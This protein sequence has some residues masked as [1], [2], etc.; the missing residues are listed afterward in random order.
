MWLKRIFG[1]RDETTIPTS[2]DIPRAA[3]KVLIT[4]AKAILSQRLA[5]DEMLA[6]HNCTAL[7]DSLIHNIN[8][9]KS[10][11]SALA[12]ADVPEPTATASKAIKDGF[13]E[14]AMAALAR[15]SIPEWN[16]IA[17][18]QSS[19]SELER[20][21][22][23][24]S[25]GP[26]EAMH[27][28]FFFEEQMA[29][30]AALIH[31][32]FGTIEAVR[33][34][35]KPVAK[36]RREFNDAISALEACEHAIA[37]K[38]SSVKQNELEIRNAK[39]ELAGIQFNDLTGLQRLRSELAQLR[40]ASDSVDQQV[41]SAISPAIRL[42]KR[43]GYAADKHTDDFMRK[44]ESTTAETFYEDEER[45]KAVLVAALA[46]VKSGQISAD[47]KEL[48]RTE[49]VLNRFDVMFVL[50]EQKSELERKIGEID[51]AIERE[52]P[53]ERGNSAA[54]MRAQALEN[55]ITSGEMRIV[56]LKREIE[57]AQQRLGELKRKLGESA[58]AV[59]GERVEV[60]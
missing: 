54:Q 26:R 1:K 13:A 53:K 27:V 48:R 22:A 24:V 3:R 14:R 34:Q 23:A 37:G 28:K 11:V 50:H 55:S 38:S 12:A 42:L 29:V 16:S 31:T 32:S 39:D 43:F 60:A 8:E 20:A 25:V 2:N 40:R 36:K 59:M 56:E 33:N 45:V 44:L 6:L 41:A 4:E 7:R 35:L 49:D 5:S 19:L 57:E 47:A 58:T 15:I 10:A 18:V 46:A 51:I 30:I 9:L 17:I 21:L 52:E